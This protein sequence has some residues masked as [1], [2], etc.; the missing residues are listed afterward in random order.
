M[1]VCTSS[2]NKGSGDGYDTFNNLDLVAAFADSKSSKPIFSHESESLLDG[3]QKL[4]KIPTIKLNEIVLSGNMIKQTPK[5]Q[6]IRWSQ[7]IPKI[8][9]PNEY[10]SDQYIEKIKH[11]LY[12]SSLIE[13]CDIY[14]II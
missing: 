8:L 3:I 6:L 14:I 13:L 7:Q 4:T 5:V 12:K 10:E 2:K 9:T 11:T 1:G